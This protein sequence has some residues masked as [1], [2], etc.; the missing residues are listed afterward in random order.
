M[1]ALVH[2]RRSGVA[3]IDRLRL[4]EEA[5]QDVIGGHVVL[6]LK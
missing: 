6:L 1:R 5:E 4:R 2:E 3:A